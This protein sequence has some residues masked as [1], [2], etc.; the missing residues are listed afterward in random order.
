[1][2][3]GGGGGGGGGGCGRAANGPVEKE[4]L[5]KKPKNGTCGTGYGKVRFILGSKLSSWKVR[6]RKRGD[7]EPVADFIRGT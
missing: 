3:L 4:R 6:L 7:K 2:G 1:M 5:K